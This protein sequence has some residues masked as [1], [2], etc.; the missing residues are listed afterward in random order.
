MACLGLE[1]RR[2]S[3]ISFSPCLLACSINTPLRG[4]GFFSVQNQKRLNGHGIVRASWW[5]EKD[6]VLALRVWLQR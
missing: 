2:H 4:K 5:D 3:M 1:R 6:I